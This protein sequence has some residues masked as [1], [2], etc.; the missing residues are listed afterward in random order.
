MSTTEIR[1][2]RIAEAAPDQLA[3]VTLI[4]N[5]VRSLTEALLGLRLTDSYTTDDTGSIQLTDS[6]IVTETILLLLEGLRKVID[7]ID[8]AKRSEMTDTMA[9]S[10]THDLTIRSASETGPS[11]TYA[12]TKPRAVRKFQFDKLKQDRPD[13]YARL[14]V[15]GY[16][17]QQTSDAYVMQRTVY[18]IPR[19][20]RYDD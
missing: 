5:L 3:Q 2:P 4:Y 17:T 11:V 20:K 9:Q 10:Q 19:A 7:D 14:E 15:D 1:L 18:D 8:C 13:L 6:G 16:I 12:Y